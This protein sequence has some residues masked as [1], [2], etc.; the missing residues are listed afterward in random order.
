ML[1]HVISGL[2]NVSVVLPESGILFDR[3]RVESGNESKSYDLLLKKLIPDA[4]LREDFIQKEKINPVLLQIAD[5][6]REALSILKMA[7][8][9]VDEMRVSG[10]QAKSKR[11]NELKARLINCALIIPDIADAELAGDSA[12]SAFALGEAGS[13]Q[14]ACEYIFSAS[15]RLG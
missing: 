7:G 12:L 11:W 4:L 15:K 2:W 9:K 1:P 14:S 10:G 13:I 3:W 6:V 8:I 5:S